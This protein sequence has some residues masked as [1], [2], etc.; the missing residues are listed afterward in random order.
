MYKWEEKHT[1][2]ST[3][4]ITKEGPE[5]RRGQLVEII[6]LSVVDYTTADKALLVGKRDASATTHYYRKED[7]TEKYACHLNGRVLLVPGEKPIGTVE[8]PTAGDVLYFSAYGFVYE[9][10]E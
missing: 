10:P 4:T 6:H 8:S 1:A 5:V 2:P 7:G 9:R 3:T